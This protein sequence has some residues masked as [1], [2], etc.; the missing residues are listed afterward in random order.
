MEDNYKRQ[1][2]QRA[3]ERI[4]DLAPELVYNQMIEIYN[5]AIQIHEQS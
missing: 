4:T 5:E 1:V 2:E 3:V